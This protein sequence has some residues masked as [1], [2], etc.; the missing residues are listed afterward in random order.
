MT[1]G[2][3]LRT[4][5]VSTSFPDSVYQCCHLVASVL[6]EG[7]TGIMFVMCILL[8]SPAGAPLNRICPYG[9]RFV[10]AMAVFGWLIALSFGK[11]TEESAARSHQSRTREAPRW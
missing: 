10:E 6:D 3:E 5:Q 2:G 7:P 8:L 9:F 4:V 1:V 11:V